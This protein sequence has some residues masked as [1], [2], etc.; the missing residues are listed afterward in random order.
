MKENEN[1]KN[2]IDDLSN[3]KIEVECEPYEEERIAHDQTFFTCGCFGGN[4][5][6]ED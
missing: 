5:I 1:L 4:T 3:V 2:D 6:T